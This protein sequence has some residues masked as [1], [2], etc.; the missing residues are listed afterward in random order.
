MK[1]FRR[2]SIVVSQVL[3]IALL[4]LH[5]AALAQARLTLQDLLS[6]EP[7]G[8]TA[9]S[10]DGKTVAFVRSGQID[11]LSTAGGWPVLLTSTQGGKT[12]LSWSPDG[13]QLAYASQGSIWA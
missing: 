11:L 10:P 2:R 3:S 7:I 5:G 4:I 8:E 12:G 6:A 9:L 1:L 13:T